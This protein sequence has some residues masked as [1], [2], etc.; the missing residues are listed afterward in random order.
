[1]AGERNLFEP[2]EEEPPVL[3]T[4]SVPVQPIDFRNGELR[5]FAERLG[6][7]PGLR[8][9]SG[10]E[11]KDALAVAF[12]YQSWDAMR[13][14]QGDIAQVHELPLRDFDFCDVAA[15]RLFEG[16][17][18]AISD[19]QLAVLAAWQACRLSVRSIYS[20]G[21][22]NRK[23]IDG[24]DDYRYQ[25]PR[26]PL[27]WWDESWP[28]PSA[29]VLREGERLVLGSRMRDGL[30]LVNKMW[31]VDCPLPLE[32]IKTRLIE[33]ASMRIEDAIELSWYYGLGD[34]W[35]A[36]LTPVQYATP[37]GVFYGYGLEWSECGCRHARVFPEKSA[38]K[39]ALV[40][41]WCRRSTEAFAAKELPD[42]LIALEFENP[43]SPSIRKPDYTR[44]N[45]AHFEIV[46]TKGGL[47]TEGVDLLFD[48]EPFT[49]VE[50]VT[51]A[52][53]F[54]GQFGFKMLSA[55]RVEALHG[56]QTWLE[57][58][59]PYAFDHD[60]YDTLCRLWTT[61]DEEGDAESAYLKAGRISKSLSAL[62]RRT[63]DGARPGVALTS[64]GWLE[65]TA[66]AL[67]IHTI[68]YVGQLIG[69]AYPELSGL[70]EETL[71]EYA[72]GFY[73]K[74]DLPTRDTLLRD[75]KFLCYALM[76]NLGADPNAWTGNSNADLGVQRLVRT[77]LQSKESLLGDPTARR[78]YE[79]QLKSFYDRVRNAL[80][81]TEE[82]DVSIS[83]SRIRMVKEASSL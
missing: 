61:L 39:N 26:Q 53:D 62:V 15:W 8:H 21:F 23:K 69:E 38:F 12:G 59:I 66:G 57:E 7:N 55:Q 45:L 83:G 24:S 68:P 40:A 78:R 42:R 81:L 31:S 41:L 37:E 16:G 6:R 67:Q 72:L 51:R 75:L 48:G 18:C 63:C 27:I 64:E 71:G 14:G 73:G 29:H 3:L 1:M 58:K 32:Q 74:D 2:K 76:R 17:L 50:R 4:K 77:D 56:Y 25:F 35:P 80:K 82:L 28:C 49:R 5:R 11:L 44:V 13:R 70:S 10:Q 79:H 9:L 22:G 65:S 36:G 54:E 20:E 46:F 52:S 33:G 34:V 30:E 47:L 19:A 60:T 43:W